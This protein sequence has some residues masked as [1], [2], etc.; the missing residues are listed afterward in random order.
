MRASSL[1]SRPDLNATFVSFAV[2]NYGHD[3]FAELDNAF[4]LEFFDGLDD[5]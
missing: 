3:I 1:R 5:S 4:F 2:A